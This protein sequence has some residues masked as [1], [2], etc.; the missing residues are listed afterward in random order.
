[1]NKDDENGRACSMNVENTNVYRI[2][3]GKPEE[4]RPL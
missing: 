2:L 4:K 3:V 1:M